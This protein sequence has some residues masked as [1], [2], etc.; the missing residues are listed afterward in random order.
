MLDCH[1][2]SKYGKRGV[3][4]GRKVDISSQYDMAAF[5]ARVSGLHT[6]PALTVQHRSKRKD[7][8]PWYPGVRKIGMHGKPSGLGCPIPEM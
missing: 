7:G 2:V 3:P 4:F 5:R 8:K 6:S 1:P